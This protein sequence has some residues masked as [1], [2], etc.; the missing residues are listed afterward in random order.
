METYSDE[1]EYS[2]KLRKLGK[3]E[4][5]SSLSRISHLKEQ[6]KYLLE[7]KRLLENDV[8]DL[9]AHKLSG[10]ILRDHS[11]MVSLALVGCYNICNE[12]PKIHDIRFPDRE[13]SDPNDIH[14]YI[15]C[16]AHLRNKVTMT[17][18]IE[19]SKLLVNDDEVSSG[20]LVRSIM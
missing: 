10:M 12:I 8:Y 7:R 18:P 13:I 20:I 4:S 1:E 9:S 16:L 17:C 14:S 5:Q 11:T 15:T 19:A 2:P 6:M 3:S